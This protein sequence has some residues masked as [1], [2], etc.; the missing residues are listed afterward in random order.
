MIIAK[1]D[2]F[3]LRILFRPGTKVAASAWGDKGLAVAD[4][5]LSE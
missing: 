2:T 4:S 1:I 5:L 3:P